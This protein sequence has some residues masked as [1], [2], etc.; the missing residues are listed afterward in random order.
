MSQENTARSSASDDQH[1]HNYRNSRPFLV[2]GLGGLA[3]LG[4]LS[5]VWGPW[6]FLEDATREERIAQPPDLKRVVERIENRGRAAATALSDADEG[7]RRLA[8]EES[9]DDQAVDESV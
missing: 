4:A 1:A 7:D 8:G 5:M 3:S 9:E 6:S 2:F